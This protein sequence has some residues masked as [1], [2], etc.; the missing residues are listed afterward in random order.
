[1][2]LYAQTRAREPLARRFGSGGAGIW[3]AGAQ[4]TAFVIVPVL[5]TLFLVGVAVS[6]NFFAVDFGAG[7]WVAGGRLFAGLSPYVGPHSPQLAHGSPFVYPA[8][9]AVLLAPLSLISH[10]AAE[11]I[12]TAVSMAA[13]VLTLR[14]LNVRDWRV[15]GLVF[16]WPPVISGWQTANVT[17]LIGLGIALAWRHREHPAIAGGLI[18]LLIS[19]KVFA[20]PLALWLLA[21]RRYAA[22][23]YAV[24]LGLVMNLIA[25]ALLGFDQIGVYARLIS[26]LTRIQ[27]RRGYSLLALGLAHG[28]S[29]TLAYGLAL[30]IAAVAGVACVALGRRGYDRPAFALS[31]ATCLLATPIIWLHYFALLLVPLAVVRPRLAPIW[32]APLLLLAFPASE[33][34]PWEVVATLIVSG[35]LTAVAVKQ[36]RPSRARV[37]AVEPLTA[38]TTPAAPA[39][40]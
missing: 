12:F 30:G 3:T 24:A 31:I 1:V 38:L 13:V 19:V 39:A 16:L 25:W 21:T 40:S 28:L 32:F 4:F 8:L 14:V 9:S 11:G 20:W 23:G 27:E 33:P 22:L 37:M 15:Y 6:G 26:A 36:A 2:G 7:P 29:R 5:L 18:A 17:L 35:A 10:A 34:R